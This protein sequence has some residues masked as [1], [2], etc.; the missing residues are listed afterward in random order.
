[1]SCGQG[2][3]MCGCRLS[4]SCGW[5]IVYFL[6]LAGGHRLI[7]AGSVL[8]RGLLDFLGVTC[9]G[10]IIAAVKAVMKMA[11]VLCLSR[12]RQ[13]LVV[14]RTVRSIGVVMFHSVF[15]LEMRY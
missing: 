13:P 8:R 1:M 2:A 7:G 11:W 9:L 3:D 12:M 15:F 4:V 6:A 5:L 14:G 10:Y